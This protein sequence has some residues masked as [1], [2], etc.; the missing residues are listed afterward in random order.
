MEK[1]IDEN[2][3]VLKAQRVLLEKQTALRIKQVDKAIEELTAAKNEQ[4]TTP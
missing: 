4:Q 2:L 1:F 3:E